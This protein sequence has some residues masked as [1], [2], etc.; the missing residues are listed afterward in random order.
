M[1]SLRGKKSLVLEA[2]QVFDVAPT[3]EQL[4]K[5]ASF[6]LAIAEGPRGIV[7]ME[8]LLGTGNLVT[9]KQDGW[10]AARGPWGNERT[11]VA[12]TSES[13]WEPLRIVGPIHSRRRSD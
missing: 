13:G 4:V 9:L 7:V 11:G 12:G 3:Q 6:E 1:R 2:C 10:R 5:F 8:V